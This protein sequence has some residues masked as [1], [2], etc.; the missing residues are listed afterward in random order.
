MPLIVFMPMYISNQVVGWLD[1][2]FYFLPFRM[3]TAD[4][5]QHGIMPFWNPY[6]YCGNPLMANMQSAVF[7]PLNI[8][9]HVLPAVLAVKITTYI[10][11]T[12]MALFTY[13]FIRLY[14]ASEEG[15]FL[16]AVVFA[17]GFYSMAKA[18]EFA[19]IN[20]MGWMPAALYFTKMCS[21]SG[22][23]RDL[24]MISFMLC[25][26]L[27]GGHAQFFIYVW[28][29]FSVFFI[30]ENI[31]MT[32]RSVPDCIKDFFIINIILLGLSSIQL[33]PTARFI[34]LS[35]RAVG[36]LG[37]ASVMSGFLSFD[38]IV[39]FIFPFLTGIFSKQ[40]GFLNWFGLVNAGILPI[41][42]MVL[43][44]FMIKETR[45]RLFLISAFTLFLLLTFIGRMPFYSA[46]FHMLPFLGSINYQS[47]AILGLFFI[48]CLLFAKGF[49]ELFSRP[50][51]ELKG[52]MLFSYISFAAVFIAYICA[53]LY[54]NN[55]MIFYRKIFAPGAS[56][57]SVYSAVQSYDRLLFNFMLFVVIFAAAVLIIHIAGNETRRG[58]GIKTAAVAVSLISLFTFQHWEEFIY[59]DP[60]VLFTKTKQMDF[61]TNKSSIGQSRILAPGRYNRFS[62]QVDTA[63]VNDLVYYYQDTFSPNFPMYYRLKNA[64]GFDSLFPGDFAFFK[65]CFNVTET[66]WTMPAFSLFSAKYVA[67][68][69][70][71]NDKNLKLVSPGYSNI[72]ENS[73]YLPPAFMIG[74]P[75]E[76][77]AV[78]RDKA[79]EMLSKPYF[80]PLKTLIMEKQDA[81]PKNPAAGLVNLEKQAG[82]PGKKEVSLSMPD[83]NTYV[84]KTSSPVAGVLVLTD[85]YYPGWK[86]Y[87]DGIETKILKVDITFKGVFLGAGSHEVRFK[88]SPPEF[89][90]GALI[91]I[92]LLLLMITVV[93]FIAALF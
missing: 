80:N 27:L 20:V 5:I 72:Y 13:A 9:Y 58:T 8:F 87:V 35:K 38:H 75:F 78:D 16:A 18:V 54:K 82:D 69:A 60:A 76:A 81:D 4:Y 25:L 50:G 57:E 44:A 26:S 10:I 62:L 79:R 65:G 7:Y 11:F 51:K 46:L 12:V 24:F 89:F 33:L 36:G 90:Y 55:I 2:P 17:F 3:L 84:V 43:G 88:Y 48:M 92:L 71:I 29:I 61:I 53:E 93:P 1:F 39:T 63:T 66:P 21:G 30:Y 74:C 49:D 41:L 45:L 56:F 59:Y 23:I 28:L 83:P 91:S 67:S 47:K 6:I 19:E 85:N 77:A 37:Y 15:S 32:G 34:L 52:F 42:F 70:K 40:S 14:K 68:I 86:A 22:K 64:D 31:Y 73:N